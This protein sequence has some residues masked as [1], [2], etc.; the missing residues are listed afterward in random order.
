MFVEK[1]MPNLP[2]INYKECTPIHRTIILD[3]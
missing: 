3:V 2:P 1:D